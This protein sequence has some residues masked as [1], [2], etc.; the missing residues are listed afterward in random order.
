MSDADPVEAKYVI[1]TVLGTLR[2]GVGPGLVRDAIAEAFLDGSAQATADV[3]RA[4]E[5]TNDLGL[6]AGVASEAGHD[7][8][9]DLDVRVFR[10]VK[11][12][13]AHGA[14][15]LTEAIGRLGDDSG[16][17]LVETKYD[18]IRAKIHAD[19]G[20]VRIFT[21]RLEDVT[22]QFPEV[23]EATEELLGKRTVIIEAELVGHDPLTG[24][25]VPFQQFSRRIKRKH[26]IDRLASAIPVTAFCFDLLFVDDR[27]LLD[28]ALD[29]RLDRLDPLLEGDVS[30]LERARHRR[31][32][33]V[34]E[35]RE[36]YDASLAA[37][38][39]G[40]MVKNLQAPYQPGS[41]VGYQL[42]VKPSM[43][44]LDLVVTRAKWSEGRKS[45][46]LGR[47]YL[48]CRDEEAGT[49][50]EVGRMH[51]GFT[52]EELRDL[53]DQLT[54]LIRSVDGREA[55]VMPS[56][57]LEVEFEEIQ[58]SP[59]YDAGYALRFPRLQRIRDDLTPADVDTLSTVVERFEAQS[60]VADEG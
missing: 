59:T 17:V 50:L 2:L 44:T 29:D 12:M 15:T 51:S 5:V 38:H 23:E 60:K 31:V 45:E 49:F 20:S 30:G 16:V 39:E 21:R 6:V 52:D 53:T 54:P 41:R 22:A 57:V 24:D 10:P 37:G 1:R 34:E 19:G 3:E 9:D 11:P 56:M 13:L 28:D 26:G 33:S 27:S 46:F 4:Y 32:D 8:L 43:D 48:A 47:P 55:R 18:G 7:G 35:A 40:V 14:D 36:V 25:P 42:K 58:R